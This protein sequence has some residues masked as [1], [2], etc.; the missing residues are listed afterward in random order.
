MTMTA[1][2]A[3]LKARVFTVRARIGQKIPM[4][5]LCGISHASDLHEHWISRGQ[6]TGNPELQEAILTSEYNVSALCNDCN[7]NYAEKDSS[8]KLLRKKSIARYGSDAIVKWM[9]N[10]PFKSDSDQAQHLRDVIRLADE[11]D[12]EP[13]L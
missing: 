13:V 12:R 9:L 5:E 1:D 6:S 10:L 3:R 7:V 11:I 4:C 2:R 8:R